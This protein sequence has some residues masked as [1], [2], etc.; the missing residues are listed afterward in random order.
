M[1][2]LTDIESGAVTLFDDVETG[3]SDV[4]A[5]LD[6]WLTA[7]E[8]L[9]PG[10]AFSQ[11]MAQVQAMIQKDVSATEIIVQTAAGAVKQALVYT[12]Y[13]YTTIT[14]YVQELVKLAQ[15]TAANVYELVMNVA[16]QIKAG[17]PVVLASLNGLI[18]QVKLSLPTVT[19][20]VPLLAT[21]A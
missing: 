1:S 6:K 17:I 11:A 7:L 4:G 5:F 15:P 3:V 12:T 14:S 16:D 18:A 8:G 10:S 19:A 13:V 2:I 20:L 21:V 9:M